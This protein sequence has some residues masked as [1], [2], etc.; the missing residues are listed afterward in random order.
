MSFQTE[1]QHMWVSHTALL[2]MVGLPG[3]GKTTLATK[4][5]KPLNAEYISTDNLRWQM[6]GNELDQTINAAVWHEA[7][8]QLHTA[9]GKS[10]VIFD[11]T[12]TEQQRRMQLVQMARQQGATQ[13]IAIVCNPHF[14]ICMERNLH[15]SRVVPKHAMYRMRD[16]F[17][18]PQKFEGFDSI[19]CFR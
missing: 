1:K 10:V 8:Y 18:L 17:V 15:R 4:M 6:V 3:S 9:M 19:I 13:V 14:N 5:V 7:H 12:N 16:N 11:A 2:L